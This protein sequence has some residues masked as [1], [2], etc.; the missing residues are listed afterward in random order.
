MEWRAARRGMTRVLTRIGPPGDDLMTARRSLRTARASGDANALMDARAQVQPA[1]RGLG[2]RGRWGGQTAPDLNLHRLATPPYA[3]WPARLTPGL[4][5]PSAAPYS[6]AHAIPLSPDRP[7]SHARRLGRGH[8]PGNRGR[9]DRLHAS[10]ADARLARAD[11]VRLVMRG[12]DGELLAVQPRMAGFGLAGIE[13]SGSG[14]TTVSS[15]GSAKQ[16]HR[17][18]DRRQRRPRLRPA[19]P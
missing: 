8:G 10:D 5:R 1:N 17:R 6:A 7:P 2:E 4:A 13:P 14:I 9:R 3:D 16:S 12:L 11:D 18:C 15:F 19:R